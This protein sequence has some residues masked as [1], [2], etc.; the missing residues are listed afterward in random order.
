[1]KSVSEVEWIPVVIR[2]ATDEEKEMYGIRCK[3]FLDFRLPERDMQE[4]LVTLDSGAVTTDIYDND[5]QILECYDWAD[6]RA[7]A[8][9][10][11]GYGYEN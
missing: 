2:L 3:S 8:E 5:W 11:K 6:V 4:V 7:W 9:M 1:M 10:P